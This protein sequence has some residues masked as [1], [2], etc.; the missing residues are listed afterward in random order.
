[1]LHWN[2]SFHRSGSLSVSGR[3]RIMSSGSAAGEQS[4]NDCESMLVI[5]AANGVRIAG[6]SL[7]PA[8][9]GR[10]IFA[11]FLHGRATI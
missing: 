9:A 5:S 4:F 8:I 10:N 3:D 2:M 7:F 1:M 11:D 6:R